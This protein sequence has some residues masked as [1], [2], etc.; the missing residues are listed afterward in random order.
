MTELPDKQTNQRAD[1]IDVHILDLA[2]HVEALLRSIREIQRGVLRV[3]GAVPPTAGVEPA[4]EVQDRFANMLRQCD[5]LRDA[6]ESGAETAATL[7]STQTK[8]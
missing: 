8:G 3:R 2:A 1:V 4:R 7:T 6:I 5:A